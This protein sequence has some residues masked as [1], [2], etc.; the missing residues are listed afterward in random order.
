M[1]SYTPKPLLAALLKR[2]GARSA[3]TGRESET[4]VPQHRSNRGMGGRPSA[5][6]LSNL[7]WLESEINGLIEADRGWQAE[8]I[9]RGIKIS[10]FD[11]PQTVPVVHAI[12]GK[13]LLF[14][15]GDIQPVGGASAWE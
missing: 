10:L 3:W 5:H 13:V 8:A 15:D 11:D 2:D 9:A 14:D 6:R 1:S 4:L 12:W 7:V